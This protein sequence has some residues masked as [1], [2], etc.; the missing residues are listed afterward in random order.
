MFKC[1]L[2]WAKFWNREAKGHHFFGD[3]PIKQHCFE[4]CGDKDYADHGIRLTLLLPWPVTS[5]QKHSVTWTNPL[6]NPHILLD[7]MCWK[8]S[9]I[10]VK[11]PPDLLVWYLLRSHSVSIHGI[12]SAVS[13]AKLTKGE[14]WRVYFFLYRNDPYLGWQGSNHDDHSKIAL[15]SIGMTTMAKHGLSNISS[16]VIQFS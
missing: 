12:S 3:Q 6:V 7:V 11:I 4:G 10:F 15:Y 5:F 14:R 1:Y 16:N 9:M 13:R 8:K 2:R